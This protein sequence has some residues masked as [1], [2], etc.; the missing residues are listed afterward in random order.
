MN[1]EIKNEISAESKDFYENEYMPKM[2][3]IGKLTGYGGV[4]LSFSPALF[5]AVAYGLLPDWG[6]LLTAFIAVASSFAVLWIVEPISYFPVLGT[7][8]TYMAFLSGNISNMRVPCASMAQN[9]ACV[10]PGTEKGSIVAT[11]GMA[12]SI[13][14]NVSVLTIGA[15]LGSKVLSMLPASVTSALGYLLPALF[16]ALLVQFG[17]KMKS[18]AVGMLIFSVL[19]YAAIK[20]GLFA[21]LPG[22]SNYLGILASVF[23]SIAVGIATLKRKQKTQSGTAE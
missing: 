5:L 6:A 16:G 12:V 11:I 3:K 8:G 9:A 20:A 18:H 15:I 21:W 19:L 13:V 23:V 7:V 22:A 10:E 14:I 2:N 1:T 17:M 4:L